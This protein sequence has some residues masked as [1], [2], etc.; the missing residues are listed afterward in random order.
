MESLFAYSYL[1]AYGFCSIQEYNEHLDILFSLIPDNVVL[2]ELEGCSSNYK[3]SFAR[4]KRY[5]DYEINTF[6]TDNFGQVLFKG[7]EKAYRSGVYD[8]ADFGKKC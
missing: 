5:F 6:N 7:L 3:D 2:L 8:I 4:L 1:W